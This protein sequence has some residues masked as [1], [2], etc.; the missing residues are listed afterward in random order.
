MILNG[1]FWQPALF[2]A[3]AYKE[4]RMKFCIGKKNGSKGKVVACDEKLV[5]GRGVEPT[6]RHN[7]CL[8]ICIGKLQ[9]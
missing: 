1:K 5:N 3:Q 6:F 4:I 7:P 9:S 8:Q 2:V